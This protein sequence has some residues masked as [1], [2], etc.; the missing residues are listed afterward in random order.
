MA[1]KLGGCSVDDFFS[2]LKP[3]GFEIDKATVATN[4]DDE[5]KP[6]SEFMKN[7]SADKIIELD[8]RPVF[9]TGK[10]PLNIIMQ[11]VK[12]LKAGCVLKIIN[13]FEPVPLMHLLGKQ[14]FESFSEK[15]NDEL[16]NTYFYK[17][18]DKTLSFKDEKNDRT[19][20]WDAI[21]NRFSG[22]LETVD[23]RALEMPLPMHTILE[24]LETL[25]A[26]KALFVYHKRIPVFLLPEL[27][28]Q[29]FNYRI[30][31]ISDTEVHLLIYKD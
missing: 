18:T 7:I 3:L 8:V 28:E 26:D 1:S 13:S 22:K 10:D 4:M 25:P 16:V 21:A 24:A 29:H 9:E 19:E 2:K 11:S 15:I 5:N 14:G 12:D 30:K 17:K 31:E 27:E 20:D 23:V 6:V